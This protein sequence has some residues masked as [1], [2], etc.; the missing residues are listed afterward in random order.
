MHAYIHNTY[1][2]THTYIHRNIHKNKYIVHN[3][4]IPTYIHT[5]IN[6]HMCPCTLYESSLNAHTHYTCARRK[7]HVH[8]FLTRICT[9]TYKKSPPPPQKKAQETV[10]KFKAVSNNVVFYHLRVNFS[11]S[12]SHLSAKYLAGN[13][14]FR[15]SSDAA[16]A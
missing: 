11:Y 3:T 1:I 14:Q 15:G 10:Q 12:S 4:Y 8:H 13:R 5:Y 6:T 2:H 16:H 7:R 9:Q